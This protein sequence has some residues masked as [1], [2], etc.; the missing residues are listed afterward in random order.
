MEIKF[1]QREQQAM[2]MML[3][4][5]SEMQAERKIDPDDYKTAFTDAFNTA[6]WGLIDLMF[7]CPETEQMAREAGY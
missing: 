6:M 3:K 1:T 7:L 4:V 5:F 2:G